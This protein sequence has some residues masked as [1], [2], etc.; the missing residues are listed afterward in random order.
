MLRR[1]FC[2]GKSSTIDCEMRQGKSILINTFALYAK[3]I[4]SGV[5]TLLSTRVA[6]QLLGVDDF[7]LYN[8]VAGIIAMLSFLNGALL[9][10]TQRFLSVAMGKNEDVGELSK[11]FNSS[12]AIHLGL[13]VLLLLIFCILKPILF[14]SMLNINPASIGVAKQVYNIMILSSLSTM[15]TVPYNAAIN[16]HEDMWMFA[17]VESLVALLK[18]G[19]A[20][21]L[22]ITP[23]DLLLTYSFLMLFA[24][25]V[26]S[27]CKYLWCRMRYKETKISLIG[28]CNLVLMKKQIGFVGWNTLGA[29]AV[30][31][32]NQ[33]VA[34]I[35]NIFF[36]TLLNAA[37]GV[38]S[39][40]NN[41]VTTFASTIT[42]VFSPVIMKYKGKGD[43]RQ[44]LYMA[45]LS[46]RI[47][48]FL[49]SLMAL[50]LL[51]ELDNILKM[52]LVEIP[53]Y[54]FQ[55]AVGTIITFVIM[56]SYPG[57]TRAIYAEGN[58]MRYQIIISITS[59]AIIPVGYV[60]YKLNCSPPV[61]VY[62]MIISQICA[63]FETV[64]FANKLLG[65]D[66]KMFLFELFKSVLCF[67]VVYLFGC[68][69]K[70]YISENI[71]VNVVVV[72]LFSV[73]LMSIL[74]YLFLCTRIERTYIMTS[75]LS[76]LKR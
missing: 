31:G 5:V 25:V 52:W 45:S 39:Q 71:Y 14:T 74:C 62:L 9:V 72:S 33:G 43:I 1:D 35:L 16:A 58:I 17:I 27:V 50:P 73:V 3:I 37:Y 76:K 20:Y 66:W 18:L 23:Y 19:A 2:G 34:I 56:Q 46:S 65:L 21:T 61:I 49:S 48:F 22:Y 7:G 68:I 51:L 8:L 13:S 12:L 67:C 57:I 55:L 41:L 28:M 11:I 69:F 63:L 36:G 6:L 32:R 47:S 54:T 4:I 40:L 24:L 75:I 42:S 60:L 64:L 15:M 30:V 53:D 26:G 10:S 44:M 29:I 38:V 59:L 70:T